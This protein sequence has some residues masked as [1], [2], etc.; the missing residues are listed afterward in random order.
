[1]IL[2]VA[3]SA[4]VIGVVHARASRAAVAAARL[5]LDNARLSEELHRA[6]DEVRVSDARRVGAVD[7]ERRRIQ[8]DLHDGVQHRLL[9]ISIMVRRSANRAPGDPADPRL[10]DAAAQLAEVV[11]ELRETAWGIYPAALAEQTLSVALDELAERAPIPVTVRVP[12]ARWPRQVEQSAYF[13]I[14]EALSN[15]YKHANAT[16]AEVEVERRDRRLSIEVTDDGVGGA[17]ATKGSGLRGL[18]ER[19]K[20]LSGVLRL[21]S[22]VAGGTRVIVELP[23]A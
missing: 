16:R 7:A 23:C 9:A 10:S 20:A 17:D 8:R 5:A 1:M 15:T 19:V 2:L 6:L 22:P 12:A 13:I 3:A 21:E 14:A 11:R 4:L 18:G